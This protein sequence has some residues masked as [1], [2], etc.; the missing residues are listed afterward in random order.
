M[1]A[2]PPRHTHTLR[3]AW[4]FGWAAR[5]ACLT[6]DQP[7]ETPKQPPNTPT[8]R[9]GGQEPGKCQPPS[10]SQRHYK[11]QHMRVCVGVYVWVFI[12]YVVSPA[13]HIPHTSRKGWAL[14]FLPSSCSRAEQKATHT[15]TWASVS[16]CVCVWAW[17]PCTV[18]SL[19]IIY[20]FAKRLHILLSSP[21]PPTP[22]PT[23]TPTSIANFRPHL[24]SR[25][26]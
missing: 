22:T 19:Y 20:H 25:A 23:H 1:R 6:Y 13:G 26:A 17:R 21:T 4:L 3:P 10:N 5:S 11:Q 15:H 24:L 14:S 7:I 9:A 2:H 12:W 16:E 8:E 18:I